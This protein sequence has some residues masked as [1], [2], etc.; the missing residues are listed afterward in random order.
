M[1]TVFFPSV[2]YV[3]RSADGVWTFDTYARAYA[4]FFNVEGAASLFMNV[5]GKKP[6]LVCSKEGI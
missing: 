4:R 3:V 1:A 2:A 5:E 6:L